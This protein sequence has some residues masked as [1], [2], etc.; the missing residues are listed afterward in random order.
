MAVKA[1]FIGGPAGTNFLPNVPARDIEDDEWEG[2]PPERRILVLDHPEVYK[3]T[4][5][6]GERKSAKAAITKAE[7]EAAGEDGEVDLE[8]APAE[9]QLPS[10]IERADADR[11]AMLAAEGRPGEA[12]SVTRSGPT[13]EATPPGGATRRSA[14]DE[15][16]GKE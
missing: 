4:G 2:M 14:K 6:D 7:K 1:E 10:A 15:G 9:V 16:E 13:E 11:A 5:A 3:V 8:T 12:E